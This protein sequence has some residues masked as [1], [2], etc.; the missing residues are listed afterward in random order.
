ML[1]NPLDNND[2]PYSERRQRQFAIPLEDFTEEQMRRYITRSIKADGYDC[3]T[4]NGKYTCGYTR[5]REAFLWKQWD[6]AQKIPT[7]QRAAMRVTGSV[8]KRTGV[9][10]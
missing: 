4:Y 9:D 1:Y 10:I 6:F 7:E 8:W 3:N 2:L 5:E